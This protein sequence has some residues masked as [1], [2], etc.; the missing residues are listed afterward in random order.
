VEQNLKASVIRVCNP[1]GQTCGT[2]FII[3]R[4]LAVT[5]AHVVNYARK[6]Q[7]EKIRIIYEI[8]GVTGEAEVLNDFWSPAEEDD[9]AVL[10][11]ILKD[12]ELPKQ[13]MPIKLGYS[14]FSNGHKITMLGSANLPGGYTMT[15]AHGKSCGVVDNKEKKSMLQIDAVPIRQGMSG[16]PVLDLQTGL[17]IGMFSEFLKGE[18]LEWATTSET[19]HNICPKIRIYP[20]NVV[21]EYVVALQKYC[22]TFPYITLQGISS[23]KSLDELYV[24]LKM[25]HQKKDDEKK[26]TQKSENENDEEKDRKNKSIP[27]TI[28]EILRDQKFSRTFILGEPGSG[29]S[30]LLRQIAEL[31]WKDPRKIGLDKPHISLLLPLRDLSQAE[32]SIEKRIS[33]VLAKN[34]TLTREFPSGFFEDLPKQSNANW[35][36]LL[37]GVDEIPEDKRA[38][39]LRWIR[40]FIDINANIRIIITSRPSAYEF[41]DSIDPEIAVFDLLPFTYDQ[42]SEFAIKWFG[43]QRA[44]VFQRELS[45]LRAGGFSNTPLL[46]TI[47]AKV[48][49]EN[50]SLPTCLTDLYSE[51]VDIWLREANQR[52]LERELGTRI[53]KVSRF[54]LEHIALEITSQLSGEIDNAKLGKTVENYLH[55]EIGISSDEAKADSERV[56]QLMAVH[57]GVFIHRGKRYDFIHATFREYLAATMLVSNWKTDINK[58]WVFIE[59]S[60]S[61]DVWLQVVKFALEI[62]GAKGSIIGNR[63]E[64]LILRLINYVLYI[65]GDFE[66]SFFKFGKIISGSV[67]FTILLIVMILNGVWQTIQILG[68]SL[69]VFSLPLIFFF[70]MGGY[71]FNHFLEEVVQPN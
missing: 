20:S 49:L 53:C 29:K 40:E 8:S 16:A 56:L 18:R 31:S 71:Y 64:R 61:H 1:Q 30:T 22:S 21:E 38:N 62:L 2:G 42:K 57:S 36:I 15:W 66:K 9:I 26:K 10:S 47:A 33:K 67:L 70:L 51:A 11:L 6:E 13:A 58:A 35:L 4:N 3:D 43:K 19:I 34:L 69:L 7:N 32:G 52:G 48:F 55:Q 45:R 24:P 17:V 46:L 63:G 27:T 25:R 37:D 12:G 23:A 14:I 41:R 68:F 60:W 44:V 54:I 65:P 28:V 59:R 5:C 50:G 39:T